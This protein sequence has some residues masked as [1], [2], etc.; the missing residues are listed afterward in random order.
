[1]QG[2]YDVLSDPEKRKQYDT[3]R[4]G[5]TAGRGP[6]NVDFGDFDLGDIFGGL[7]GGG[8]GRGAAP[9]GAARPARLGRRGRGADLVRGLAQGAPDDGPG[10]A[11]ARLPHLPRHRRGARDGAEALPE[12]RRQRRRRDVAGAVRA[13]AAVPDLPRQ[14]HDRRHA[15]PDLPRLR[16][17]AADEALHGADPGRRQGRH[18]D[19]AEGQGRG[20]LGR[21]A[22]RATCS[23][24]R[25]SSRRSSTS[26]A[27]TTS[28]STCRSRSREAALGATRRDPDAGRARVAQGARRARRTGSS[29]ASR[30]AARRSSTAPA[31]GDLLARLRISVPSKLTKAEREA[32][33]GLD[34][35]SKSNPRERLFG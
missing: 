19:Q 32:L 33:E 27:A 25:G 20:R 12:L 21:R 31:S 5:R 13:A 18:E 10:H 35:A 22:R 34:K 9:A 29:C 6:T 24:S 17:R 16:P 23:S 11:R 4:L 30:A 15:V 3:L 14:R 7:F 8:R 26:G 1:M 2:A 28:C